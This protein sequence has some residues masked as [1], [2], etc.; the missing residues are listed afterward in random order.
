MKP[1]TGIIIEESLT[2]TS[3]LN[4]VRIISTLVEPV[5]DKHKTPWIRQWTMHTVEIKN[6]DIDQVAKELSVSIDTSHN[7]WYADFKNE[8]IHYI[9]YSNKVFKVNRDN[10]D[11]YA[12]ASRYG[13][14]IGIPDYQ[15]DFTDVLKK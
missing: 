7:A 11:E 13:I 3:V 4:K 2:G 1:F 9:I 10:T 8:T 5:V 15:V 6:E 14:S 12:E